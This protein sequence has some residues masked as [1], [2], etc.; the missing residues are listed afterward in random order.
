MH[1][2]LVDLDEVLVLVQTL[3]VD[4]D[5]DLLLVQTLLVDLEEAELK[6]VV[7]G[8]VEVVGVGQVEP[9]E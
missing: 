2:E 9:D 3:L 1:G 6:E 7:Q 8:L 5:D 4:L